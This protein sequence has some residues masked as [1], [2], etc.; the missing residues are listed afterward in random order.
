MNYFLKYAKT[1]SCTVAQAIAD[2]DYPMNRQQCIEAFKQATEA[3]P[4]EEQIKEM[5]PDGEKAVQSES[6]LQDWEDFDMG[7]R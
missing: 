3:L 4:T 7:R 6:K 2:R 1:Y 5:S